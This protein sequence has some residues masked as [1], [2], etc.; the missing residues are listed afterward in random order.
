MSTELE[1]VSKA[2]ADIDAVSVG[3]AAL[4]GKYAG[5]IY[6]VTTPKGMTE[7]KAARQAIREPRYDVERIRKAAKKP[8]LDLGRKLDAEAARIDG[9][10]LKLESP[11]DE[12]IKAEEL[13]KVMEKLAIEKA[14]KERVAAIH[15]RIDRI[16]ALPVQAANKTA[17]QILEL[18]EKVAAHPIGE[19]FAE[20]IEMARSAHM[21]ARQGSPAIAAPLCLPRDPANVDRDCGEKP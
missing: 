5:I 15:D 6:P 14:E 8:I 19:D 21:A 9:E 12:Q 1:V 18:R 2:L 11:I 13:R 3:I 4:R 16:R 17:A 10:L 7:A 20:F